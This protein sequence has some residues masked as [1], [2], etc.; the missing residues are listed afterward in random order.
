MIRFILSLC[1]IG[2]LS[3]I[4]VGASTSQSG[5]VNYR[6]NT[7]IE[8]IDYI[9]AVTPH[10][11]SSTFDGICTITLKTSKTNVRAITLH[12]RDL[13]II[14]QRLMKKS[15]N[16]GNI[17][18]ISSDYDQTTEKYTLKLASSLAK[19]ELYQLYFNYTGSTKSS[20]HGFYQS[21]YVE[22]NIK[23]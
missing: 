21:S 14:E 12:Q 7:D 15:S 20:S 4:R 5:S 13:K 1:L 19:D 10:F 18:I 23:K 6:L 16:A 3:D 9:I 17:N 22:G 11:E 2:F 8:P